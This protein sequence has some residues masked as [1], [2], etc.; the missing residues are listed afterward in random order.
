MNTTQDT[1]T[2]RR[3]PLLEV[4]VIATIVVIGLSFLLPTLRKGRGE[5]YSLQCRSNLKQLFPFA[6][7]YSD[8]TG[9]RAFPIGSGTDPQAHESL[10]E[11]VEFG[12]KSIQAQMF[13]CPES[14]AVDAEVDEDGRFVL[15]ESTLAYTWVRKRTKNTQR[16]TL[17]SDKYVDG[18]RDEN[19]RH[20]GHPG[21]MNVLYTACQLPVEASS[22]EEAKKIIDQWKNDGK[23][24][25]KEA[26]GR[27]HPYV[28]APFYT[29]SN[30]SSFMRA[31]YTSQRIPPVQYIITLV[32]FGLTRSFSWRA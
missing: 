12:S 9:T 28:A 11:L 20:S 14:D 26:A 8:K 27:P 1:P 24:P 13:V 7:D 25:P 6:M 4:V 23:A 2:P 15:D 31:E 19:G 3:L 18:Y 22:Q 16:R 5:A 29:S 30:P 10:N 32:F 17:T 21:G